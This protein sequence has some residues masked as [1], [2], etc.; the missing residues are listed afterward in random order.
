MEKKNSKINEYTIL[1]IVLQIILTISVVVLAII[2]LFNHS[3]FSILEIVI[4]F[5]MFVMAYNNHWVYR[6]E[7]VTPFYLGVGG[8]LLLIGILSLLGVF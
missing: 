8:V 1:G 6:R 5:D 4:G 3:L 7:K 2:S